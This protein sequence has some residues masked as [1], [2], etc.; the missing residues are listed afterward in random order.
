[1]TDTLQSTIKSIPILP[2]NVQLGAERIMVQGDFILGDKNTTNVNLL[3]QCSELGTVAQT[4]QELAPRFELERKASPPPRAPGAFFGRVAEL[5][6]LEAAIAGRSAVAVYGPAGVGKSTLLH[7]AAHTPAAKMPHGVVYLGEAHRA[8]SLDDLLQAAFNELYTSRISRQT[9]LKLDREKAREFFS[10]LQALLLLDEVPLS[11]PDF[12]HVIGSVFAQSAVVAAGHS[13]Q[14]NSAQRLRLRILQRA[15]AV[16]L[17]RARLQTEP[18]ET[19]RPQLDSLCA[20]LGDGP[21]AV[22]RAADAIEAHALTVAQAVQLAQSVTVKSADPY[23]AGLERANA[24]A[25]GP[26]DQRKRRLLA[27]LA[28]IPGVSG[29]LKW[30]LST[31]ARE[32]DLSALQSLGLMN[33]QAERASLAE[34]LRAW[35]A[36]QPG[37]AEATVKESLLQF[38][39]R[40]LATQ[41]V[42]NQYAVHELGNVRGLMEWAATQGRWPD[43]IALAR[44]FHRHAVLNGFWDGWREMLGRALEAARFSGDPA[45]EAWAQHELGTREL[46]LGKPAPAVEHLSRAVELR[47]KLNDALGAAV[48][49]HNLSLLAPIPPTGGG[50]AKGGWPTG[51]A[52]AAVSLFV[53][54]GTLAAWLMSQ[55]PIPNTGAPTPVTTEA[56]DV[57]CKTTRVWQTLEAKASTLTASAPTP[58]DTPVFTP[59]PTFTPTD[60]PTATDTPSATA[61]PTLTPSLTPTPTFTDT[62]TPSPTIRVLGGHTVVAVNGT[63]EWPWC[64][65]RAYGVD[66]KAI[67]QANG[68]PGDPKLVPGQHLIIPDVPMY[69]YPAGPKCAPQFA[70]PYEPTIT[71]VPPT[72]SLILGEHIVQSVT[73]LAV[74]P[75]S[76]DC[77]GR[78]YGVDPYAIAKANGLLVETKLQVWQRLLIPDAPHFNFTSGPKCKLQFASPYE[79]TNTPVPLPTTAPAPATNYPPSARITSPETDVK[80]RV[81]KADANGWYKEVW[82]AASASDYEDGYLSGA[83]LVW[84]TD[85]TKWQSGL[86]GTGTGLFVRLY[87]KSCSD[88]EHVITLTVTDSRG[89]TAIDRRRVVL[90]SPLC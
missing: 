48:S 59:T 88:A 58:T 42:N 34:G 66:P 44:G 46:A 30:L 49:R 18:A 33:I 51:G 78:A 82:L 41:A 29:D 8:L 25:I 90:M 19:D 84:A 27:L 86:L 85:R 70:S 77:I 32:A 57:N 83:A 50:P 6:R 81:D 22:V 52:L 64:I 87:N 24:L 38:L 72:T 80:F 3:L 60:T 21:L 61:T 23:E 43:V 13:P 7:K 15:E 65:G 35:V 79:P 63:P 37:S 12:E 74:I 14:G 45:S 55:W 73:Y 89:N 67:I 4:L 75:E 20:L 16:E 40:E 28:F 47:S 31:G 10:D 9:K 5:A 62:P 76:L 36:Q 54:V 39:K 2:A 53:I 56:C 11:A 69:N 71:P 68:L 17:L 1:M 26:L